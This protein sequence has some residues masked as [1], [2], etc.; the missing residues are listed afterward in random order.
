MKRSALPVWLL[1]ACTF[2]LKAQSS[3]LL[4]RQ[5]DKIEFHGYTIKLLP[6]MGGT[7]GY[8]ILKGRLLLVRQSYNPFTMAPVGL[9]Q[10]DDVYKVAKWQI[11][12]MNNQ[13]RKSLVKNTSYVYQ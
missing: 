4:H 13:S 6:A 10:K 1:F 8:D 7:Y 11:I 3:K 2:Q 5:K 9:R 12:N